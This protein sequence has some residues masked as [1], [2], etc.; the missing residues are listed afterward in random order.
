MESL[1]KK[2]RGALIEQ[3]DAWVENAQTQVTE[4][5]IETGGHVREP[6]LYPGLV[7]DWTLC[8]VSDEVLSKIVGNDV[9]V[10]A[11]VSHDVHS[12]GVE[13]F[14]GWAEDLETERIPFSNFLQGSRHAT[15]HYYVAQA[16][17]VSCVNGK[18]LPGCMHGLARGMTLPEVIPVVHTSE[19]V[20]VNAWCSVGR[21]SLSSLHYDCHENLL[22]VLRG[23]KVVRC[24]PFDDIQVPLLEDGSAYE[25]GYGNHCR[26]H[27]TLFPEYEEEKSYPEGY[28]KLK[29][30]LCEFVV[31]AGDALYIPPGTWHQVFSVNDPMVFATNFWWD[32]T[33][34]SVS[35]SYARCIKYNADVTEYAIRYLEEYA[36]LAQTHIEKM[37]QSKGEDLT[38]SILRHVDDADTRKLLLE[39]CIA[40]H[41]SKGPD[42]LYQYLSDVA[43]KILPCLS[44]EERL[45]FWEST[46][47]LFIEYMTLGV[48]HLCTNQEDTS[49]L[50]ARLYGTMDDMEGF[51]FQHMLTEKKMVF[52]RFLHDTISIPSPASYAP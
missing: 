8:N 13:Y 35:E 15:C 24:C 32:D 2:D 38:T 49:A 26:T 52:K 31:S 17:I 18:I 22:C 41:Y 30:P 43:Y 44:P 10:E 5:K 29:Y 46:T 21:P 14:A 28:T 50:Y 3:L 51:S 33:S 40:H 25:Y 1:D 45:C 42:S 7:R 16:P 11:M 9:Y 4:Q 12:T 34:T 27:I 48:S 20:S 19:P 36:L 37:I 23:T 47:P 39:S 6:F